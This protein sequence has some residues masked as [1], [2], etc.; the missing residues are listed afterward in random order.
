MKKSPNIASSHRLSSGWEE[1]ISSCR[2]QAHFFNH[3]KIA[4]TQGNTP[5]SYYVA[6]NTSK[7]KKLAAH[8]LTS[9][10]RVVINFLQILLQHPVRCEGCRQEK[11]PR[12]K[13]HLMKHRSCRYH[14]CFFEKV[15]EVMS[16][17]HSGMRTYD[18]R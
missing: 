14:V 3:D 10:P 11:A 15:V 13:L 16:Y 6:T 7:C 8:R 1:K 9:A 2:I 18:I 5:A 12:C 4:R 17:G